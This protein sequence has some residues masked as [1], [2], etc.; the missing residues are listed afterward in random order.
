MDQKNVSSIELDNSKINY[1]TNN[2]LSNFM[3][4]QN[5]LD[6]IIDVADF[7]ASERTISKGLESSLKNIP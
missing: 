4:N 1:Y 7:H 5:N 2:D 6:P 3:S